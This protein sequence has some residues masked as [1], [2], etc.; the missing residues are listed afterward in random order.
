[1]PGLIWAQPPPPTAGRIVPEILFYHLERGGLMDV[2]P[3]LLEKTLAKGWRAV[4]E[5]GSPE[6]LEAIDQELWSYRDD[7]F[8]PHGLM[9]DGPPAAQPILLIADPLPGAAP[10]GAHVRFCIDGADLGAVAGYQRVVFIFDGRDEAALTHA[11]GQWKRAKS[12]D[13]GTLT[14]W[15]QGEA[16]GWVK[17]A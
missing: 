1:M 14:Y 16:G 4:V 11:R 7:S 15:Q 17:K 6:R 12:D 3:S 5:L 13:L 8:L 10:N 2:L 9:R